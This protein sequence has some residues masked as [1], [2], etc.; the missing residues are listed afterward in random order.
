MASRAALAAVDARRR[1]AGGSGGGSGGGGGWA[2]VLRLALAAALVGGISL[3]MYQAGRVAGASA[4]SGAHLGLGDGGGSGSGEG[5]GVG[6]TTGGASASPRLPS[7]PPEPPGLRRGIVRQPDAGA[8]TGSATLDN[9]AAL[10]PAE[11]A[12]RRRALLAG[13]IPALWKYESPFMDS[14]AAEAMAGQKLLADDFVA[15]SAARDDAVWAK[16]RMY[17]EDKRIGYPALPDAML[18][19]PDEYVAWSMIRWL[20]PRRIVE[21][22]CGTSTKVMAYAVAANQRDDPAATTQMTCIEPYRA[23]TVPRDFPFLTVLETPVQ[24]ADRAIFTSLAAGDILFLDSSH[25]MR[26]FGDVFVEHMQILPALPPGVIV[27]IHDFFAPYDY[28]AAWSLRDSRVYMEQWLTAALLHRNPEWQI[29]WSNARILRE[30]P[31]W[32]HSVVPPAPE[33]DADDGMASSLWIRKVVPPAAAAAA[34]ATAAAPAA[35]AAAP[36]PA[37]GNKRPGGKKP[38]PNEAVWGE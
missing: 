8:A 35:P 2:A 12:A 5:D 38:L 33:Y 21:V 11:A 22:G 19:R 29:L 17:G 15:F 14:T 34:P 10:S 6:G 27:H 31:E 24:T 7:P 13:E 28:P 36:A 9:P 37:A 26:P 18:P 4:A 3:L 32:L 20:K 1:A 23:A 30:H 16:L 25:V